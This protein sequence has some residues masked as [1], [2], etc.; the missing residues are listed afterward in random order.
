MPFFPLLFGLTQCGA[1]LMEVRRGTFRSS[2]LE[3]LA[4]S[5]LG[6]SVAILL[7]MVLPWQVLGHLPRYAM[8]LGL[9]VVAAHA[10]V[11]SILS[12]RAGRV[13]PARAGWV[14][15]A[16]L[17][18]MSLPCLLAVGHV[19]LAP[20]PDDQILIAFP[21]DGDWAV[22]QGGPSVLT[23]DHVRYANQRYALDLV[24]VGPDGKGVKGDGRQLQDYPS[25]GQALGAPLPGTVIEAIETY[26][27]N[28]PGQVDDGDT[29]GNHVLIRSAAGEHVLLAHLRKGSILVE[30]G[31]SVQEGQL[32]AEAGNSGNT[33]GPHLHIEASRATQDGLV[34]VPM[35]F[36][37][38]GAG[39]RNQRRGAILGRSPR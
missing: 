5:L 28:Q 24:K 21:A 26:L 37:E 33:S 34:S 29:R 22:G 14:V 31:D 2:V 15:S 39:L 4:T 27:D 35:V 3:Q 12:Y 8:Y 16:L 32:I 19:L 7:L 30:K 18:L 23:N 20:V 38:I 25:W 36:K 9:A 13:L 6:A 10:V 11:A 1:T 17:V